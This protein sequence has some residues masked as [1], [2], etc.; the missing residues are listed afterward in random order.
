M[1]LAGEAP[2]D[3][4]LVESM[5]ASAPRSVA[6]SRLGRRTILTLPLLPVGLLLAGALSVY[7][8]MCPGRS[9]AIPASVWERLQAPPP[10][11]DAVPD[12]D[13]HHST[14]LDIRPWFAVVESR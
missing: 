7:R 3:H 11:R 4:F 13:W 14:L 12:I 9:G 1:K 10:R 2:L 8:W 6:E 5:G